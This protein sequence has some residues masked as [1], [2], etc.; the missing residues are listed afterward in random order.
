MMV[1]YCSILVKLRDAGWGKDLDFMG[2]QGLDTMSKMPVIRQSSKLT[3]GGTYNFHSTLT[4]MMMDQ[5]M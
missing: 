1:P 2:K 3:E 5:G 4:Y